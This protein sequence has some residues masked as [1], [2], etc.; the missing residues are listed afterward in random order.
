MFY[1]VLPDLRLTF[2]LPYEPDRSG[3]Y[4]LFFIHK[5]SGDVHLLD[6]I[7]DNNRYFNP[8][9]PETCYDVV[10]LYKNG[11]Y[12][13]YDDII[14]ED[15]IEV[16]MSD[17]IIQP[18]DSGSEQWKSMRS[19]E[20]AFKD[21]APVPDDECHVDLKVSDFQIKG[22]VLA[23]NYGIHEFFEPRVSTRDANNVR[24]CALWFTDGYFEMNTEDDT[25][26]KFLVSSMAYLHIYVNI[27]ASCGLFVVLRGFGKARKDPL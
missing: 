7:K 10:V 13:R 27:R 4:N 3:F 22:Y 16:D 26:R 15:G 14:L 19:F 11:K 12:V 21:R 23:E 20:Y 18:S 6:T 24:K 8:L 9:L 1:V 17:R 2:V 5:K 25:E